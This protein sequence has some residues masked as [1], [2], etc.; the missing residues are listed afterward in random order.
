MNLLDCDAWGCSHQIIF[1]NRGLMLCNRWHLC[2]ARTKSFRPAISLTA[3]G[4]T[5]VAV[6]LI[7][8]VVKSYTPRTVKDLMLHWYN[9]EFGKERQCW[10]IVCICCMLLKKWISGILKAKLRT[11]P[12]I[13][14]LCFSG[15]ANKISNVDNVKSIMNFLR[16]PA[17]KETRF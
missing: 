3:H 16:L 9:K 13:K 17:R 12:S 1:Q 6:F 14:C 15:L 2:E 10:D 11:F 4:F 5:A 7:M 8:F